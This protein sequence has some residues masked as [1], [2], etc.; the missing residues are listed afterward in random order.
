MQDANRKRIE[1]H[2]LHIWEDFQIIQYMDLNHAEREEIKQIYAAEIGNPIGNT[3]CG[4]CVVEWLK[5]LIVKYKS[6]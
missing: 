5:E 1:S 2:Y 4:P 6:T 3:W